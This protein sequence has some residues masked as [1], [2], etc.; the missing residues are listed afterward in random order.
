[1]WI[2][3]GDSDL[4]ASRGRSRCIS[5]D[6]SAS[7]K[8]LHASTS[9]HARPSRSVP[10]RMTPGA[11]PGGESR[12]VVASGAGRG[13]RKATAGVDG[14]G[15]VGV[16]GVG[17]W[18]RHETTFATAA[19]AACASSGGRVACAKR[20]SSSS[21]YEGGRT[22]PSASRSTRISWTAWRAQRSRSSGDGRDLR[23][24]TPRCRGC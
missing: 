4:G 2:S 13:S 21:P 3:R 16:A 12:G 5:P 19:A 15:G 18:A 10:R 1:M 23:G 24:L 22:T 9:R 6:A 17:C 14:A 20:A 11:R 8:N 7:P